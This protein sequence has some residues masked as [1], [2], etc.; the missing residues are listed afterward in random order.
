MNE[1]KQTEKERL[2]KV[3]DVAQM[4]NIKPV[5]VYQWYEKGTLKGFKLGRKLVRFRQTEVDGFLQEMEAGK[6][7]Y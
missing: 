1:I 7:Y 2:L 5:T 4:L 6:E 3:E